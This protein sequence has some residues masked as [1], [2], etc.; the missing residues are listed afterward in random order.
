LP[1]YLQIVNNVLTPLRWDEIDAGEF[2]DPN[3]TAVAVKQFV[4]EAKDT[5]LSRIGY[6][7]IEQQRVID[8]LR[9]ITGTDADGSGTDV[10]L[11]VT[12]GGVIQFSGSTTGSAVAAQP[13]DFASAVDGVIWTERKVKA[14]SSAW[15]DQTFRISGTSGAGGDN[16]AMTLDSLDNT[17]TTPF[18]GTMAPTLN[19]KVAKD[20]YVLP[21][22]VRAI[23][24][25]YC[26]AIPMRIVDSE[27]HMDRE[28]A[29][30]LNVA[31]QP[32]EL[33]TIRAT[34]TLTTATDYLRAIRIWPVQSG[35]KV[36][37]IN[38]LET[39]PDLSAYDDTWDLEP[40]VLR[41]IEQE[42]FFKCLNSRVQSDPD[43]AIT[44]RSEI[45]KNLREWQM[46]NQQADPTKR[47]RRAG[48]GEA[49][50]GNIND[51]RRRISGN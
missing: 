27:D 13:E 2:T 29:G 32:R 30:Q 48:P 19:W 20:E 7:L 8:L 40:E 11:E 3:L 16:P 43:L 41:L 36:L 37:R 28:H 24:S 38:T 34:G 25:A 44:N 17:T 45:D 49:T 26:D 42:A 1:T 9:T 14:E 33:A 18:I 12:A 51:S 50:R 39:L 47:Y 22:N 6:P 5:I 23:E 15:P 21:A 10:Y 46:A 31:D 4:N 35:R